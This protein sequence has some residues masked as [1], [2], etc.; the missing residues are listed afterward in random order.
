MEGTDHEAYMGVGLTLEFNLKV[1]FIFQ[2]H[3]YPCYND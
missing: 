2:I 3:P 1:A